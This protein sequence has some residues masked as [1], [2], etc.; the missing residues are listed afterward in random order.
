MCL[1]MF[2][3]EKFIRLCVFNRLNACR[4]I[5]SD[6][7]RGAEYTVNNARSVL[8]FNDIPIAKRLPLIGTKLDFL[9]SGFGKRFV[10]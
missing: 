8:Q 5:C 7:S 9:L 6:R 2:L 10:L 1:K 4:F 3:K